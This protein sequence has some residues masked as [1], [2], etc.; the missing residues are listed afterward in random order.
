MKKDPLIVYW[1]PLTSPESDFYGEWNMMYPE[2]NLLMHELMEKR[3]RDE[4]NNRGF[5]QCPAATGR[6]KHTYVFR[7]GMGSEVDFDFTNPYDPK[8]EITGKTS[9]GFKIERPSAFT[10]GGSISFN[11]GYL[12]FA[13]EPTI[14]V[15]SP[16]MMHEPGYTKYGTLIP[17]SFDISQWF[18]P[19][20]VEIQTWKTK[21]KIVIE[22]NEP[23]FYF[24]VL[25]DREVIL[26]RFRCNKNLVKYADACAQAPAYY[27]KHLP[28]TK[29][30]EKFKQSKMNSIVLNE[31]KNNLVD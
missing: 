10:E 8:L 25:T 30:Y 16:P 22:E 20:N 15:F 5:L 21:G 17:G 19:M 18:R 13:E 7:T 28:L 27:G 1:A 14:G 3:N 11:Q 23:L 9:V 12:F 4:R 29:R 31:I 24:E 6:F 2:P 26:K